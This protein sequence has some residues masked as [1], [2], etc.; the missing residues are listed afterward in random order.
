MKTETHMKA[1]EFITELDDVMYMM[2]KVKINHYWGGAGTVL[3][4]EVTKGTIGYR[5]ELTLVDLK[6]Y[7]INVLVHGFVIDFTTKF[8][9]GLRHENSN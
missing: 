7:S 1:A 8:L 6:E 9:E 4:I 2:F 5:R 3:F